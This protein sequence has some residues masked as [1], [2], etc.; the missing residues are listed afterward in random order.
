MSPL[1]T[2]PFVQR[3][4]VAAGKSGPPQALKALVCRGDAG[5]S[6]DEGSEGSS[7]S[8]SEFEVDDGVEVVG[9]SAMC[10]VSQK[11]IREFDEGLINQFRRQWTATEIVNLKRMAVQEC[12][13]DATDQVCAFVVVVK[14]GE[15]PTNIKPA[16]KEWAAALE[17]EVNLVGGKDS[18][19]GGQAL[20]L[21]PVSEVGSKDEILPSMIICTIKHDGSCKCRLVA[22]DSRSQSNTSDEGKIGLCVHNVWIQVILLAFAQQQSVYQVYVSTAVLQSDG[23]E[24]FSSKRTF[25]RPP[26][27]CVAPDGWV[28]QV[29]RSVYGLKTAPRAWVQTLG[30]WLQSYGL[31]SVVDDD[32]V[33]VCGTT[34]V[35][36]LVGIVDLMVMG[37]DDKCAE[38]MQALR[39]QFDNT[40]W[41]ALLSGTGID[42]CVFLGH[43]LW[44]ERGNLVISQCEYV[45]CLMQRF[46]MQNAK[47][48]ASLPSDGFGITK[49]SEADSFSSEEHSWFRSVLG[50]V[51]H[52]ADG[53]RADLAAAVGVPVEGEAAPYH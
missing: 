44:A 22:C 49:M 21:V 13:D 12:K 4:G 33:W 52:L 37:S 14:N 50:G 31:H 3:R 19:T 36:V 27:E 46:G 39:G 11:E 6:T 15:V 47:G 40:D 32:S 38:L 28:W 45:K 8:G 10:P 42:P 41:V 23:Q 25:L 26:K 53:S 1:V 35:V 51:R 20:R 48:L 34:G 16:F 30:R 2:H 9:R 17:K 43:Q 5:V 24:D 7:V 29:I 18:T